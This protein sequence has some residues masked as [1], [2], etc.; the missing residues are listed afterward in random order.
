MIKKLGNSYLP[1]NKTTLDK[2]GETSG[3]LTFGGATIGAGSGDG[4]THSN[5]QT[6]DEISDA[7]GGLA[8]KG[9]AVGAGGGSSGAASKLVLGGNVKFAVDF[10][11]KTI[12]F[13]TWNMWTQS[14][15]MT[16]AAASKT[17]SSEMGTAT[18]YYVCYK[19]NT[20]ELVTSANIGS[21]AGYVIFGIMNTNVYP[22]SYPLNGIGVRGGTFYQRPDLS[23]GEWTLIGDSLTQGSSWWTSVREQYYIPLITNLAVAG[24]RMSGGSGM[25]LDKDTVTATTELCT[26]MGGTND[27]GGSVT[28]GTIQPVGSAFDTN[29]FIGAY[30]TLIEGLLVKNPKMRIILMTPPRAWTDTTGT[31]LRSG[32]KDYGDDVKTVGQFYN[33]PVI[34]MY[35]NMGYNEKNQK[36]YLTDGLHWTGEGMK[37]VSSLVCGALRTY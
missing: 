34:D 31:T 16:L 20:I 8:Y 4:H 23:V 19:E 1:S 22:F 9:V 2:L 12:S 6:L 35:H 27:Q 15:A 37:R 13:T 14:V 33:L 26:I 30:Q 7:G 21:Y 24:K 29:T 11:A 10:I 25:W 17:F 32:L 18:F 36:T 5:K 3:T 28:R